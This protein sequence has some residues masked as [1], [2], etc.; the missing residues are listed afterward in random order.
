MAYV[1]TDFMR[2]SELGKK[3]LRILFIGL[4]IAFAMF[5]F[6][7]V[8]SGRIFGDRVHGKSSVQSQT[9]IRSV[10]DTTLL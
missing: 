5:L 10:I 3:K 8:P 7:V 1:L 9:Q 2:M 4:V 6:F